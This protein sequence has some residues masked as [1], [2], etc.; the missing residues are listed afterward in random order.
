MKNKV[1]GVIGN[2]FVGGA[3]ISAFSQTNKV[4]SYD[5]NPSQSLN[6]LHDVVIGSDFIF[7]CVPTP[8]KGVLG[9]EIDLSIVRSVLDEIQTIKPRKDSIII[10][11]SSMVPGSAES[12]I[13]DYPELDVVY[14]P[15]F[16]REKTA[17]LDFLNPSRIVLGGK[18]K[19]VEKTK[20]LFEYRFPHTKLL[21]TDIT[22]AQMIKYMANCFLSTKVSFMNEMRQAADKLNVN[23][24][25]AL[26]GFCLDGRIGLSHMDVPGPD[27][28]Y[29]FGGKCFPKDISAFIFL[30]E[31]LGVDP[32]VMKAAWAKNLAVR[33]KYDWADIKGAV[34]D[35]E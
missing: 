23:W 17:R 8:M 27:G 3:V 1:I 11:K 4:V 18:P 7:V 12:L 16:L 14:S 34:S 35:S 2:G 26:R 22:T 5:N 15:E 24:E 28:E 31:E 9:G 6:S 19:L 29:G 20:L 33:E 21:V 13:E 30:F 32:L 25:D 10:L